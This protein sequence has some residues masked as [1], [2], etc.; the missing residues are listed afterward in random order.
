MHFILLEFQALNLLTRLF[1]EQRS[2]EQKVC[3]QWFQMVVRAWSGEHIP[4]AHHVYHTS[5]HQWNLRVLLFLK[6][7]FNLN[8]VSFVPLYYLDL[9]S[10]LPLSSLV[11]LILTSAQLAISNHGLQTLG[12]KILRESHPQCS[13][14]CWCLF[15]AHC[16]YESEVGW[17]KRVCPTRS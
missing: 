13:G 5:N 14:F 6:G 1:L 10:I 16:Q 12:L 3:K 11:Y 2:F 17:E 9:T 7:L 15:P 8:V 4:G